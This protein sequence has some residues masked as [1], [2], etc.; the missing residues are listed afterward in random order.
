MKNSYS[1]L[2][3]LWIFPPLINCQ[4]KKI[5]ILSAD[6]LEYK[7]EIKDAQ[8][9]K[10]NVK[11]EHNEA[12]M[13]CDSAYL[14][15]KSNSFHAFNNIKIIQN[16][17]LEM[18]G[19]TLFYYGNTKKAK[20]IGNVE[21]KEA[22]LQLKTNQLMYD[23]SSKQASYSSRA[24]IESAKSQ[25]KLTSLKGTYHSNI[26]TL[27]FKDSVELE[28]PKYKMNSDTLVYNTTTE[29]SFFNGPSTITSKSN[30]IKCNN[31]WYDTKNELSSFWNKA[32]IISETQIVSGDSIYY[33]SN[34]EIG[35]I[36]GNILLYDT[37]DK[38]II[39]GNYAYHNAKTD[40][41]VV[42]QKA[43]LSQYYQDDTLHILA[44]KFINIDDSIN[45]N[46]LRGFGNVRFYKKDIQGLCDS[47]S[48]KEKDSTM[49]LFHSPFLW[50]DKNQISGDFIQLKLWEG[51]INAMN[52]F[53]NSF[54]LSMA[55]SVHFNQIKGKDMFSHFFENQL[56]TIHVVGNGETIYYI[57]SDSGESSV[58]YNKTQCSEL[59]ILLDS[60]QIETLN[61][62]NQPTAVMNA[63]SSS[64]KDEQQLDGFFW[65]SSS[66]PLKIEFIRNE[67]LDTRK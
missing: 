65:N 28:H 45:L 63:V 50:S 10:G 7:K 39:S 36:F 66:R 15:M 55:D 57:E 48:Y 13:T 60:N 25:N 53:N 51:K 41:S 31:G 46:S 56:K 1:I 64:N 58:D 22:D 24:F 18:K 54:I 9:L 47:I 21:L 6:V 40:S 43:M 14:F 49:E 34:L 35:K 20:I 19:D 42:E 16:D 62:N 30:T 37:I 33:D 27:F 4:E 52:I 67:K 12:I 29:I 3:L 59:T 38:K 2:L 5:N 17:S 8:I 26:K 23:L 11:L 44:D 32:S 61:F